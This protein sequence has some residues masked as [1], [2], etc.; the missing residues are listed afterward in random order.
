[1]M[2]GGDH[3]LEVMAG[4]THDDAKQGDIEAFVG[5]DKMK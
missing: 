3:G 1:V 5:V 4:G 2:T